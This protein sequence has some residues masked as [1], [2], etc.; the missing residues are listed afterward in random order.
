[1]VTVLRLPI[2]LTEIVPEWMSAIASKGYGEWGGGWCGEA[3]EARGRERACGRQ[4]AARR[5]KVMS[6]GSV[7]SR[8]SGAGWQERF[9]IVDRSYGVGIAARPW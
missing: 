1:M 5:V 9:E 6:R 8:A 2:Y 4:S 3:G 7:R